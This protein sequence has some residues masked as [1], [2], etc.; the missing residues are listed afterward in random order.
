MI[1]LQQLLDFALASRLYLTR[2]PI[3][4]DLDYRALTKEKFHNCGI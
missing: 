2:N 3:T 1:Y 4:A